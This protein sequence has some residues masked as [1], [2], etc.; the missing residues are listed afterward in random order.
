MTAGIVGN[1]RHLPDPQNRLLNSTNSNMCHAG[2]YA[3]ASALHT[4]AA[5]AG[6]ASAT[7][8]ALFVPLLQIRSNL[9]SLGYTGKALLAE[10]AP[11]TIVYVLIDL[12]HSS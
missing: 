3:G 8:S 11:E 1:F 6:A 10:S 2:A 12:R 5:T 4:C 7:G 9:M